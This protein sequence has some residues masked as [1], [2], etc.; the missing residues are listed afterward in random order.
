MKIKLASQIHDTILNYDN[1][2]H[3]ICLRALRYFPVKISIDVYT[4]V[5]CYDIMY[6]IIPCVLSSLMYAG[7][8][9][10]H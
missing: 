10:V 3:I 9:S 2:V 7:S 4:M 6:A 5:L 8:V 1:L